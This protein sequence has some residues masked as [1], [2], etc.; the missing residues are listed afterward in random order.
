MN[1]VKVALMM[2]ANMVLSMMILVKEILDSY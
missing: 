1:L 2:I